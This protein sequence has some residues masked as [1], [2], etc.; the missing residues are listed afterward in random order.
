LDVPSYALEAAA[1]S[2]GHRL[3]AGIDEA[4]RGPLAGP[5]VA[6]A[7]VLDPD[8]IPEGLDDSKKLS[9]ARREELFVQILATAHVAFCAAPVTVI[10]SLNIRGATLWAMCR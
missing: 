3:V 10:D 8:S 9:E 4:G 5:V 6:A 7:V 1:M 2:G